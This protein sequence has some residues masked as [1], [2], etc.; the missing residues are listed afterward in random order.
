MVSRRSEVQ[1]IRMGRRNLVVPS[2]R[3]GWD[4]VVQW[5]R[6]AL[7]GSQGSQCLWRSQNSQKLLFYEE[8]GQPPFPFLKHPVK[9]EFVPNQFVPN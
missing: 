9:F 5:K 7:Q 1:S 6:M 8:N 4:L 3:M 2:W